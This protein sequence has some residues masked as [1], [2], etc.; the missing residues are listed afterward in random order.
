MLRVRTGL[1]VLAVALF[2]VTFAGAALIS[3]R[4]T[5]LTATSVNSAQDVELA[6]DDNSDNEDGFTVQRRGRNAD[7]SWPAWTTL[8]WLPANTTSHVD[9][10]LTADGLYQY[11]VRA[12]NAGARSRWSN[13]AW[14]VR[15]TDPPAAP[16][17]LT[18][19]QN[20]GDTVDLTWR[21]NADNEWGFVMQRRGRNADGTW[22]VWATVRRLPR[23]T[24]AW[25]DGSV[26]D[27]GLYQ[28]RLRAHNLSGPSDWSRPAKVWRVTGRPAAPSDLSAV[29]TPA[30]NVALAW[31]NNAVNAQGIVIQR[32]Q[33]AADVTWP[34]DWGTIAR[35]GARDSAYLDEDL[36]GDGLY[37]YRVRAFNHAGHSAWAPPACVWVCTGRPAAPSDVA[38]ELQ[39]NGSVLLTWTDNATNEQAY[40]IQRRSCNADGTWPVWGR[41]VRL[42]RNATEF[43]DDGVEPGHRYQYRVRACNRVGPSNWGP[44][45]RVFV[46]EGGGT[47]T[48]ISSVSIAQANGQC[49]SVVYGLTAAADVTVEVR[50]IAGRL[51]RTIPCGSASAALNTATWNL[52]NATGAPVPSG[53]YLC[54]ITARTENGTQATAV[55]TVSVRR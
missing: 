3:A 41:L 44:Y 29:L 23:D 37:Q 55:R 16:D 48:A 25:T 28:Y 54:T 39:P 52:R 38:A 31:T 47:S 17:N 1:I 15:G 7:G 14:V 51:V 32:R 33:Q 45:A 30:G 18:A 13:T 36:T 46:G 4:P 21:D 43:T 35:L 20:A 53:M 42:G 24:E 6:W 12:Y 8:A 9:D 50:N 19:A 27:D 2:S 40:F 34:E 49:V 5:N 11:R 22:P 26:T 10:T